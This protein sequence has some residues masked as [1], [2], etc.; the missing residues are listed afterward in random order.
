M[1]D[2]SAL[3]RVITECGLDKARPTLFLSECVLIYMTPEESGAVISWASEKFQQSY[4]VL[5]EQVEPHD[6]FG[7]AM[8]ENLKARQC[9]LLSI[10]KYPT[11]ADQ[12][13]RFLSLGWNYVEVWNMDSVYRGVVAREPEENRRL[14]A[15]EFLDELE[16]WDLFNQHYFIALASHH[17]HFASKP[18]EQDSSCRTSWKMHFTDLHVPVGL[19]PTSSAK[20]AVPAWMLKDLS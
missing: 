3:D 13:K 8:L 5:Y 7:K 4:F 1:R 16:E 11:L 2:V 19:P 9:P 6:N 12:E 15:L 18:N 20:R 10:L 17:A 14:N